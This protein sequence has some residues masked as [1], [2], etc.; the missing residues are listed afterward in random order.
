MHVH[1]VGG[2]HYGN[3]F[4]RHPYSYWWTVPTYATL[5]NW[6]TWQA[7]AY[8]WQQPVYYDYGQGGNVYYD[9][10]MVYVDGQQVGTAQDFAASA[11]NLATVPAP[12]DEQAAEESDWMPLGTWAV[13]TS[14]KEVEPT[15]VLQ[16]AVNR[17][18]I[19][20]GTAFNTAT[21]EAQT[22]LG[23]VDKDTQRVAFRIGESDDVVVE[24]GLFN[25]TQD[26]APVMVHFGPDKVDYWLLVRLDAPADIDAGQQPQP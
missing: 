11:A 24:T 12:T 23:Q 6:F 25:L 16:I 18:G 7:P 2:W 10:N 17:E 14:E 3:C 9:N 21:N 22:I 8:A 20:S 19:V 26:E 4:N 1:N 15:R 13:S 5:T